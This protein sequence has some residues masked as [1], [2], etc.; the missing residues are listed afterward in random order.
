MIA[1]EDMVK[2]TED[3]MALLFPNADPDNK[4]HDNRIAD[5]DHLAAHKWAERDVFVTED[6]GIQ[7]QRKALY[8]QHEIHVMRAREVVQRLERLTDQ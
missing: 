4:K 5:V 3:L 8:D 7:G 6:G 2:L 1:G